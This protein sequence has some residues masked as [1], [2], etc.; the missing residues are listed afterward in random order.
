MSYGSERG[1]R[2]LGRG[3]EVGGKTEPDWLSSGR[4]WR[5]LVS[6]G[7]QGSLLARPREGT[8]PLPC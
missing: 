8:R 5:V 2:P 4:D 1:A 6:V 3:H 7:L